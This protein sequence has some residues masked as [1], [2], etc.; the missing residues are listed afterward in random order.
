MKVQSC[1]PTSTDA[2]S[3]NGHRVADSYSRQR[4]NQRQTKERGNQIMVELNGVKVIRV[5]G[6]EVA[7]PAGF[8]VTQTLEALSYNIENYE[9][10]REGDTLILSA[11]AGSKGVIPSDYRIVD[12]KFVP[13]GH[14]NQFPTDADIALIAKLHPDADLFEELSDRAKIQEYYNEVESRREELVQMALDELEQGVQEANRANAAEI[15]AILPQVVH[16][17]TVKSPVTAELREA[18][19]GFAGKAKLLV[20]S[21]EESIVNA[22]LKEAK[23]EAEKAEREAALQ[24]LREANPTLDI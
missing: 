14:K 2:L 16:Y 6:Q 23:A 13:K 22:Q 4:Q 9:A 3:L 7:V 12:G 17:A 10:T 1:I 8:S 18:L 15:M 21:A 20:A 19:A 24:A 11:P 5:S